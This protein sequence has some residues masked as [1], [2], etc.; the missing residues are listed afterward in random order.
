MVVDPCRFV[1][2][3]ATGARR[4]VAGL[5]APGTGKTRKF[6]GNA[7]CVAQVGIGLRGSSLFARSPAFGAGARVDPAMQSRR[8][9][10]QFS[11]LR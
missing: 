9:H 10:F 6:Y 8:C 2:W 4:L 3:A 1:V 11:V 5:M 7:A